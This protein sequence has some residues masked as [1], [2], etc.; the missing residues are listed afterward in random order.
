MPHDPAADQRFFQATTRDFLAGTMPVAT[1]RE[2][3]ETGTGFD[4][5]WWRR[6]A[7]LGWTAMLVPES[8]G[9]GTVSGRPM[10]EL[11]LVAMELGRS[12]APG[13]FVT[14]NAVLAGL[15]PHAER[16]ADIVTAVL[17]GERIAVWAVYEPGRGFD[18]LG[19]GTPAGRAAYATRIESD[20]TGVRLTGVKDRVEAGD[21]ADLFLVT[22]SGPRGPVQVLVPADAPGVT[23]E[24]AWTLDLVRRT[25]RVTFDH[26][27]VPSDAVVNIGAEAETAVRAQALTAAVLT[28]AES[29]GAADSAFDA[30]LAWLSDRY[31]FGRPLASYQALKHRMADNKTWLEACRATAAAAAAAWDDDPATAAEAVG[32]AKSYVGAKAPVIG[33]DCVQLHGGIGVTWEHDLHLY[34]RRITLGR[35]LYGTPEEHRRRITDL[36]DAA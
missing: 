3:G 32:I 14:T 12:C 5:R 36:L 17:S 18:A 33:Q 25:A 34:L 29:V 30:T 28:A 10:T 16:F 6:G 20:G 4:R 15:A 1:V 11:A 35:A 2:L 24:P 7:E 13:P 19:T 9:G 27:A 21:Q 26:V 31:T 8:L 23:V 22:A